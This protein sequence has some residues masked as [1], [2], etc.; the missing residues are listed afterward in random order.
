M[1]ACVS[2][3]VRYCSLKNNKI[4]GEEEQ[5]VLKL[6]EEHNYTSEQRDRI[7]E[8]NPPTS[9]NMHMTVVE[10]EPHANSSMQDAPRVLKMFLL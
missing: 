4:V 8:H 7:F 9:V 6:L 5:V 10:E 1:H 2:G 3:I